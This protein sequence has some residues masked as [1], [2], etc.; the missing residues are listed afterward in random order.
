[1]IHCLCVI[2]VCCTHDSWVVP[3]QSVFTFV[4]NNTFNIRWPLFVFLVLFFYL[5][6][7][8]IHYNLPL[9]N[10]RWVLFSLY[11]CLIFP[12]LRNRIK[13]V[14]I[15]L[16]NIEFLHVH[17]YV[18]LIFYAP[19]FQSTVSRRNQWTLDPKF[20]LSTFFTSHYNHY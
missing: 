8:Y 7:T 10:C 12:D 1:M 19:L 14:T 16:I 4:K 18:N 11:F 2:C 13:F 9:L 17:V 15:S 5:T 3:W 20:K 6:Y